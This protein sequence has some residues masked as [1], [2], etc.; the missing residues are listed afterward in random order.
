MAFVKKE[1]GRRDFQRNTQQHTPQSVWGLFTETQT[2]WRVSSPSPSERQEGT[3]SP[4]SGN[5]EDCGFCLGGRKHPQGAAGDC[6]LPTAVSCGV[7][8]WLWRFRRGM[9]KKAPLPLLASFLRT[10]ITKCVIVPLAKEK[11]EGFLWVQRKLD[12]GLRVNKYKI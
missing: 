8:Q 12:L 6:R 9:Q 3:E 2:S 5:C 10:L 4:H 1:Q 11:T 7:S